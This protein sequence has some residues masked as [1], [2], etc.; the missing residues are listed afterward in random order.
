MYLQTE[1]FEKMNKF[2]NF[3]QI[4]TNLS[5]ILTFLN[6]KCFKTSY[7]Y[8]IIQKFIFT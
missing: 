2:K 1:S 3:L 6:K 4:L 8:K 7:F 5:V